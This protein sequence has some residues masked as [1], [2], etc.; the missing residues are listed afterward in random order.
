[1]TNREF[2]LQRQEAEFPVFTHVFEALPKDQVGYKPDKRCPSAEQLVWTITGALKSCIDAAK[3]NK[4]EAPSPEHPP[5]DEMLD[6]FGRWSKELTERVSEMDDEAWDRK[7]QFYYN[8]KL[9][10]EQP[11]GT[12]LWFVLFDGIHH[13]GQLTAY[14]R[15]MG[16]K[17]PSIYG[18]SADEKSQKAAAPK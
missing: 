13:R 6:M 7:A 15:P 8:G 14:L 12:F 16:G 18:P 11:V 5:L 1:M 2:F 3:Q 4:A 9:V 17:V 10:S